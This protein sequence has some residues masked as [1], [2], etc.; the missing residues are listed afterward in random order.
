[1]A[2]HPRL[3]AEILLEQH[4]R[5]DPRTIGAAFCHHMGPT[6]HGYPTAMLPVSPSGTSRLVRVCDVFEALTSVRPYKRALTPIEAYAVMFRNESDFDSAWLRRFVRTIGL[7][8][9]GSRV[10]LADGC[11]AMV[12][13]QTGCPERPIVT[14]LSGPGDTAVP[15][16]RPERLVIGDLVEGV[17]S[18]IEQV[19]TDDRCITIPELDV[20]DD[21]PQVPPSH[22]CWSPQPH[23]GTEH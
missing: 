5:V 13:A 12:L 22:A 23:S 14:L 10:R 18:R 3:G 16:G 19:S 6:G 17:P 20:P 1:M 7:F 2:Q 8:P 21:V 9:N 15:A 11:E 4:E